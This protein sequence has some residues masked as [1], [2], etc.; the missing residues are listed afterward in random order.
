MSEEEEVLLRFSMKESLY[1]ALHPLL[2]QYVG[3]QEAEVTP[4]PDGTA[5]V[6]WNIKNGKHELFGKVSVNWRRLH[7][8]DCF[9]TSARI[10]LAGTCE[11]PDVDV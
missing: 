7:E 4:L 10:T 5:T 6:K 8:R 2:C 9:L 1:K 11:V 3:F